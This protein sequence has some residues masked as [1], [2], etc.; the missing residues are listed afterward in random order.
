MA[1]INHFEELEI[2][3]IARQLA[4]RIFLR[5]Q[6]EPFS[7]DFRFHDQIRAASGSVMDNV[8]EGFER[9]SRLEYVNFLS[10]AKGAAGETRS[11]LY[12]AVDQ[13]Y[14]D[15][16]EGDELI[17]AYKVLSSKLAGF[18]KVFKHFRYP[19]SKI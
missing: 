16:N 18:R 15:K 17:I 5:T 1:T 12:R 4:H 8:A 6:K 13:S 14:I 11:Q 10:I 2:W 3:Q 9:S 19:G 7:K